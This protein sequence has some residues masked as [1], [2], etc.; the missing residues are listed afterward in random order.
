MGSVPAPVHSSRSHRFAGVHDLVPVDV[1]AGSR[2]T[3]SCRSNAMFYSSICTC[4]P[5]S[6]AFLASFTTL[7]SCTVGMVRTVAELQTL[8]CCHVYPTNV[9]VEI[10]DPTADY[11][12]LYDTI[13]IQGVFFF[14]CN[15][16]REC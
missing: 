15:F 10:E 1:R 4:V 14:S 6:I 16:A 2:A 13:S 5:L 3:L 12:V 7:I 8:R 11:S 9:I